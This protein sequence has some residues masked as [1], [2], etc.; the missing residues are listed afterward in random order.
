MRSMRPLT[1]TSPYW[2][3]HIG[4]RGPRLMGGAVTLL[5]PRGGPAGP[6]GPIAGTDV[7][8]MGMDPSDP[9]TWTRRYNPQPG[10]IAY[11]NRDGAQPNPAGGVQRGQPPRW[12]LKAARASGHGGGV[13][14]SSVNNG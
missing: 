1:R 2:H 8:Y 6:V 4:G 11:L 13:A 10:M 7:P 5:T 9:T 3:P 14:G 12:L